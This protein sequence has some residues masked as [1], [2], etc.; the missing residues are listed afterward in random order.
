MSKKMSDEKKELS[1]RNGP[2]KMKTP[3]VAIGIQISK[4]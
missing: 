1:L 3:D 2:E 4:R